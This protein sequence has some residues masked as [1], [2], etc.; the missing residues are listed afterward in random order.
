M[1]GEPLIPRGPYRFLKH[2]NYVVVVAEI[3]LLPLVFGLWEVA[4]GFSVLNAIVLAIRI[5]AESRA[6]ASLRD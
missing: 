2:P 1:P 4:L 3:A 5:H 6:L